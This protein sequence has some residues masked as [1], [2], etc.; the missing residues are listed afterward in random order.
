MEQAKQPEVSSP[1]VFIS[2]EGGDGVGKS[3]H[4]RFLAD[5]LSQHGHEVVCLR[6]PGGTR[7]GE[8]LRQVV[9][10]PANADFSDRSELLVFEAARAQLVF[11]VIQPALARGAVV[12]CDRFTDSTLA[13][14]SYGRQLPLDFVQA[15]NHFACQGIMP[16]RT[17][18][19]VAG[20]DAITA[21]A[22]A[23]RHGADRMEQ[24]GDDFHRRVADGFARLAQADPQ[25]IRVVKSA[26]ARSATARAICSELSDLFPWLDEVLA[27][28]GEVFTRLD[29]RKV[30]QEYKAKQAKQKAYC[31][32]SK[33]KDAQSPSSNK[34]SSNKHYIIE[35][36]ANKLDTNQA[37]INKVSVHEGQAKMPKQRKQRRRSHHG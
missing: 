16:S 19:L 36:S 15:A 22:R 27:Q 3:T 12:L 13:Y 20:T 17:I 9:L 11:E 6:E 30:R 8:K 24:G 31:K 29:K 33:A 18:L 23:T 37:D 2:F 14:Q 34:P 4:I 7:I 21:L 28:E 1:G 26:K 32:G 25:R 5:L 35:S 10:N